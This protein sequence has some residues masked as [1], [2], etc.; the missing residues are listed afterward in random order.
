MTESTGAV[1]VTESG[2]LLD[3]DTLDID[4]TLRIIMGELPVQ[5]HSGP[6]AEREMLRRTLEATD[7]DAVLDDT[8]GTI[9]TKDLVG[10]I[11]V[12]NSFQLRPS[13]EKPGEVYMLLDAVDVQKS[14]PITVNT[15]SRK[16]MAQIAKLAQL[17]ELPLAVKVHQSEKATAAGQYPLSLRRPV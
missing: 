16:I 6:E 4:T 5:V 13:T 14:E 12:I 11:I 2:E 7:A 3:M 1:A 9:S 15:G 17:G 10:R 8:A